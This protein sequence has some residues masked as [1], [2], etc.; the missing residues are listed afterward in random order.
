MDSPRSVAA[1]TGAESRKTFDVQRQYPALS[2][3][4]NLHSCWWCE[5]FRA[6]V[7]FRRRRR[8]FCA[9]TGQAIRPE[10]LCHVGAEV[11][12]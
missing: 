12:A 6:R 11:V 9:F 7:D 2:P 4:V 1:L 5:H 10:S 3:A 8:I